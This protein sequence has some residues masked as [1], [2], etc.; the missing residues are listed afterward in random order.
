MALPAPP[1]PQDPASSS[2]PSSPA[3]PRPPQL[4][5]ISQSGP[6]LSPRPS[7]TRL[8][9]ST[10]PNPRVF[11]HI[12]GAPPGSAWEKRID[13]SQAGVH[14][15]VQ[16][17]ISGTEDRGGAESVVLNDGYHDGDCGDIIWYM[18]SGGY[19]CDGKKTS[20][21][22]NSQDPNSSTN[23]AMQASLRT[24]NP[25]RVV[26]GADAGHSPWAPESGYRYD[27]LYIVTRFDVVTDPSG[28]TDYTCLLFRMERLERDRYA[29]PIKWDMYGR[30]DTKAHE[31][32]ERL[33]AEEA[34]LNTPN[35]LLERSKVHRPRD[36]LGSQPRPTSAQHPPAP[37]RSLPTPSEPPRPLHNSSNHARPLNPPSASTT[38]Q[39]EWLT[40]STVRQALG[41]LKIPRKLPAP[42]AGEKPPSPSAV[43]TH[44]STS[45]R[46]SSPPVP[47]T[48]AADPAPEETGLAHP[49]ACA[50][51]PV[52][53]PAA[54]NPPARP[55]E[56][57][58]P[59]QPP[60]RIAS[61]PVSH[62]DVKP[63]VCFGSP[64]ISHT[65]ANPPARTL[66]RSP[67][68]RAPHRSPPPKN[69]I[70]SQPARRSFPSDSHRD[71]SRLPSP[72]RRASF[73]ARPR[74]P[75]PN[76][77]FHPSPENIRPPSPPRP[78]SHYSPQRL[79]RA[80]HRSPSRD[81][82]SSSRPFLP[83]SPARAAD[84]RPPL[85]SAPATRNSFGDVSRGAE[86][87]SRL[88][89]SSRSRSRV[90]QSNPSIQ[91]HD[92][93]VSAH[94]KEPETACSSDMSLSSSAASR[95]EM[96]LSPLPCTSFITQP[97]DHPSSQHREPD[98]ADTTTCLSSPMSLDS[99]FPAPRP[100]G[101]HSTGPPAL[102]ATEAG[103]KN[104]P[105]CKM[106]SA[107]L[108]EPT[109]PG[110]ILSEFQDLSTAN[111]EDRASMELEVD[112]LEDVKPNVG[113]IADPQ[114]ASPTAEKE[115][116]AEDLDL[117]DL[118]A[119]IQVFFTGDV[120]MLDCPHQS[121]VGSRP[122]GC[123][124]RPHVKCEV[125]E[126]E[127][128]EG[129][130]LRD[131][132]EERRAEASA[133]SPRSESASDEHPSEATRLSACATDEA[134]GG[135]LA[136]A[137]ARRPEEDDELDVVLIDCRRWLGDD[138]AAEERS[139]DP[140]HSFPVAQNHASQACKLESSVAT[141]IVLID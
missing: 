123:D 77:R 39:P 128:A 67:P 9:R 96:V 3:P 47:S 113:D 38:I 93:S 1:D 21:M 64:P 10:R 83:R 19:T 133:K 20:V 36:S 91:S 68:S 26:R 82:S 94:R 50:T 87:R 65:D 35:N 57:T 28:S 63:S 41:K 61:P 6:S 29:L 84:W 105:A 131:G 115:P 119:A 43:P 55:L 138:W 51:S 90:P 45:D 44:T 134:M 42:P 71:H 66:V 74:S 54:A 137:A 76:R 110:S 14:A 125:F 32:Q 17:G 5:T 88:D 129:S 24:R 108:F 118:E 126:S 16:S 111:D 53:L 140:F 72:P 15:P 95:P 106:P 18:G 81:R 86:V 107:A 80:R 116:A 40:N 112:E 85:R 2:R 132:E 12:V 11:G 141:G 37:R 102:H 121:G 103:S 22:Q 4:A 46:P 59:I 49:P 99:D 124:Q 56:T 48:S 104:G 31:G 8:D 13:V 109:T 89:R 101:S 139:K 69:R 92:R 79:A 25:V 30:A 34:G 120:V 27:G 58:R 62:A 33:R 60:A 122:G 23:R 135:G 136:P 100:P 52:R 127:M 78:S 7:Q 97:D 130:T 75:S 117:D 98:P 73:K 70:E 114:P